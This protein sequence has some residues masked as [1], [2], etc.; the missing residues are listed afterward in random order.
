MKYG[1]ASRRPVFT[2]WHSSSPS[3]SGIIQSE[4]TRSGSNV[5]IAFMPSRPSVA[6]IT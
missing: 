6:V 5:T 4:I 1:A 3:T 2:D